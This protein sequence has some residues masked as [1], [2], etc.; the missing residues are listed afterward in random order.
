MPCIKVKMYLIRTN[1]SLGSMIPV[2]NKLGRKSSKK[3]KEKK[4][5]KFRQKKQHAC[6]I[7][8]DRKR[9]KSFL[10]CIMLKV[11]GGIDLG[12]APY[13]KTVRWEEISSLLFYKPLLTGNYCVPL[14]RG[15]IG[16]M[17]RNNCHQANEW[18]KMG[19]CY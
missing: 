1:N 3:I 5:W 15:R 14:R 18:C 16:N 11:P 10:H 6:S 9:R 7:I 17:R 2:A 13:E 8:W 4:S 12:K 19:E